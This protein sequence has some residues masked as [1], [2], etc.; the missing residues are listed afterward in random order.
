MSY[1]G[2][3]MDPDG[4]SP[5]PAENTSTPRPTTASTSVHPRACGEHVACACGSLLSGGSSPRLRGTLRHRVRTLAHDRGSSPRLRG[6][7]KYGVKLRPFTSVHPRACGEHHGDRPRPPA[8]VGSSPRLRG[9]LRQIGAR[10]V[11]ERFIPAPA[12][13]TDGEQ[14]THIRVYGSSPRLRGTRPQNRLGPC[15]H[16]F[17]PAPAGNTRRTTARPRSGPVHPR[18][19]GEHSQWVLPDPLPDGS[20]PRLR[21]TL[22]MGP[23]GPA[24]RRFIP[25]PAGNTCF[26][27]STPAPSSVHP[28]ACGEHA[29]MPAMSRA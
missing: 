22:P 20:S 2:L 1:R 17:I 8:V 29:C 23:A 7:P 10:F 15:A 5:R 13:N 4:S 25:A 12:G 27:G 16:R 6:T 28:R 9:T 21:G 14:P 24:A 18:A 19:C 3:S 11:R 26:R